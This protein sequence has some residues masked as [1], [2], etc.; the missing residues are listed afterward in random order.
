M[1]DATPN[2]LVGGPALTTSPA[3]A[4]QARHTYRLQGLNRA[5][6]AGYTAFVGALGV[7]LSLVAPAGPAAA[8]AHQSAAVSAGVVVRTAT[9]A[10]YGKILVSQKGLALYYDTANKPPHWACT[11][12]CLTAWPPLTVPKSETMAQL[13]KGISGLGIV[14]GPSGR[15]VTWDGKALY[16]FARDSKGTVLG[17]GL[18]N[19]W[20]VAQPSH[21]SANSA[22]TPTGVTTTTQAS[23]SSWG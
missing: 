23:G 21:A 20:Y 3:P 22:I 9:V 16:T 19:V 2:T 4:G 11:G 12:G 8:A 13:A 15:Q 5:R 17:Q 18:G 1:N 10:K 6:L 7:G 14:S